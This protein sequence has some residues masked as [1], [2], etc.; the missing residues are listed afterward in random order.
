MLYIMSF[1]F[2]RKLRNTDLRCLSFSLRYLH[3]FDRLPVVLKLQLLAGLRQL[4]SLFMSFS[5]FR[6]LR[7]QNL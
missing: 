7:N 5:F 2:L 6:K 3:L 4:L 1:R